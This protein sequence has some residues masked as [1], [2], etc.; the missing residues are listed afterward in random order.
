MAKKKMVS[1]TRWPEGDTY[2]QF[3]GREA[4]MKDMKAAVLA[5]IEAKASEPVKIE[6]LNMYVKPEE[7]RTY[8]SANGPTG[9]ISG[10]VAL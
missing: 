5:D 6:S 3:G 2:V 10:S 4:A 7:G 1:V 9:E 8:Y